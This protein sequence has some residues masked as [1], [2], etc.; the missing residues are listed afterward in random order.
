MSRTK[1]PIT[2]SNVA[3]G[4]AAALANSQFSKDLFEME[5]DP[6]FRSYA[7]TVSVKKLVHRVVLHPRASSEFSDEVHRLC[8][9]FGSP[10]P[11][12]SRRNRS[13]VY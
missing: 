11:Q 3:F 1:I 13:P 10:S 4:Q 8:A 9:T 7:P 12:S 2:A 6:D 5:A